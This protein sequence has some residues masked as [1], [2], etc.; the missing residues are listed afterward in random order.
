MEKSCTQC[1]AV[2]IITESDLAFYEKVSPIFNGKKE[3]IPPPTLCPPCRMQRRLAWRNERHLHRT[4]CAS[5]KKPVVSIYS[6]ERGLTIYCAEC[7]WSD[8]WDPRDHGMDIDFRKPFYEQLQELMTRVPF[9]NNI[10]INSTNCDYNTPCVNSKDCYLCQRLADSENCLYSY[11]VMR[12]LGCTDCYN[13][14]RCQYCY[15]CVD[16]WDCYNTVFS[17]LCK[18]TSDSAFCY[19][20]ISCKHCIGCAGLRNADYMLFNKKCTKEEFEAAHQELQNYESL[21]RM[22][23]RF[24]AEVLLKHPRRAVFIEQSEDVQGDFISKS[25]DVVD[26]FDVEESET[27]RHGWGIEY[28]K[29]VGDGCFLY[30][31]NVC[32]EHMSTSHGSF[33]RFCSGI[34]DA[35]D[36]TCC[37]LCL[38]NTADCFGCINCKGQKF[39]IL[40]KQ[41]TKEE[42]EALVP[43]IIEKMR[44]EGEWGEFFPA[45]MSPF[46]YGD[47]TAQEYFPLTQSQ[48]TQ[49]GFRWFEFEQP[50]SDASRTINA[51]DLPQSIAEIPDDI[52]SWAI[53]C[54][55]TGRLFRIVKQELDFF[56]ERHLPVPHLHPDERHRLR[57]AQ[58]N[59]KQLWSRNCAKCQKPIETSYSPDRPEIVFC[60]QCYLETVY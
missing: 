39:C 32:Y 11:L 55:T 14:C 7:Y 44:T 9:Q 58:R 25:R 50:S 24:V 54:E 47:T 28:C 36:L 2:F 22:R 13:I 27:V 15:H 19:D 41:Y 3:L 16:C 23:E 10:V 8:N 4:T 35:H 38:G 31:G 56:R 17:Q 30:Y 37:I 46:P 43:K 57:V 49:K 12:C 51:S 52:L 18:N 53:R 29:D 42:Y 33:T 34:F 59:P 45:S 6:E 20:C 48:A 40:N 21:N 1:S 5:C 26:G 60:E